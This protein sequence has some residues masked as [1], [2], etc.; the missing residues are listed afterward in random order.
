MRKD[1]GAKPYILPLPVFVVASY[2]EQ[3]KP[4][5]L[6]AVWGGISN[7]A[8]ITLTIASQRYTLK[9]ILANSEFTVSMADGSV[10]QQFDYLGIESGNKEPDKFKKSGLTAVPATHVHAPLI[11]ELPFALEC[12]VKSYDPETWRLVAEIVNVSID[13]R[14]FGD[15]GKVDLNKFQPLAFDWMSKAY[16][17]IGG[18]MG[19]AYL[20]GLAIKRPR[21]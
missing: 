21:E 9:G 2:D 11:E 12:R 16:H 19:D 14:V 17:S 1:I 10:M 7:E 13:E 15:T 18:K 3:E 4:S 8:E 6:V 5:A 20:E